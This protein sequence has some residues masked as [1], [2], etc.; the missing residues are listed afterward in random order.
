M[1][2]HP[3]ALGARDLALGVATLAAFGGSQRPAAAHRRPA[4]AACAL[5]DGVDLLATL[6]ARRRVPRAPA[7]FSALAAAGSTAIAL[8][9]LAATSS[10]PACT[11]GP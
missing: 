1:C 5:S 6:A 11:D 4:L 7:A 8:A 3:P 2:I 10:A 9:G